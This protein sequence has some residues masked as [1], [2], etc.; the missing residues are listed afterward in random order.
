M[1]RY[2]DDYLE[3]FGVKHRS[4]RYKWGSGERPYQGEGGVPSGYSKKKRA[5][6]VAKGVAIGAGVGA[7][8]VAG[9]YAAKHNS[10][11]AGYLEPSLKNGKGNE[12][13]SPLEKTASGINKSVQSI[14]STSRQLHNTTYNPSKA[15]REQVAKMS[16]KELQDVITRKNLERNYYQAIQDP[17]VE[18]GYNT[19]QNI[20][21]VAGTIATIAGAGATIYS[22]YKLASEKA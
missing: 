7:A 8:G 22:S 3:H 13:A 6:A 16:N 17:A 2:Y 21:A 9:A 19:V 10:K 4:G 12:N 1:G 5:G 15:E 11:V 18:S 20:L 14:Q